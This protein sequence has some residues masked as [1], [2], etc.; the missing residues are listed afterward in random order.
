MR[1]A[2]VFGHREGIASITGNLAR[3]L[4]DRKDWVATESLAGEALTLSQILG[5]KELIAHACTCLAKALASQDRKPEA[6]PYAERA[7]NLYTELR[8]PELDW[9]LGVLRECQS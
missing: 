1:I 9:A 6:L 4:L 5:R 3:L 7:V 2:K 8:S